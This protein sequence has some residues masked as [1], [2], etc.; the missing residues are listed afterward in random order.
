[1]LA[2]RPSGLILVC[3]PIAFGAVDV[4]AVL[5]IQ[6]LTLGVLLLWTVRVWVTKSYRLLWPP[7]WL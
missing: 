6:T 4:P 1:M 2:D 7:V 5:V 3:G